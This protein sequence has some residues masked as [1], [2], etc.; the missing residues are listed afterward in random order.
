MTRLTRFSGETAAQMSA[1]SLIDYSAVCPTLQLVTSYGLQHHVSGFKE[2][3][4]SAD[5]SETS[6]NCFIGLEH[7]P[8]KCGNLQNA[9]NNR[10]TD[11]RN[12]FQEPFF[13]F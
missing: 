6:L 1:P 5:F 13:F 9:E 7:T 4:M 10:W 2:F 11:G 8:D 12:L 3:G